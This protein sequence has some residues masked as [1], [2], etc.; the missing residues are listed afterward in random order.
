MQKLGG[1]VLSKNKHF[2]FRDELL[3]LENKV[4]VAYERIGYFVT[5]EVG[6]TTCCEVFSLYTLDLQMGKLHHLLKE[7]CAT[8]QDIYASLAEQSNILGA[9]ITLVQISVCYNLCF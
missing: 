2:N 3:S 8:W 1:Q 4:I 7:Q 9:F 6:L 5:I